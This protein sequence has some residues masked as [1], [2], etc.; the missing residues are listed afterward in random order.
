M[1][2]A[3]LV[4]EIFHEPTAPFCE[5]WVLGRIESILIQ[6]KIPFFYD[7]ARNLIAGVKSKSALKKVRVGFIAHADHPGFHIEKKVGKNKY[8][9]LWYGGA[10]FKKMKGA[11]IAIYHPFLPKEKHRGIISKFKYKTYL[12]EGIPFE[13]KTEKELPLVKGCFGAFDFPALEKKGDLIYTRVADDLTGVVIILG[14]LIDLK[15]KLSKNKIA[16]VF[17]RAEEVGWVGCWAI[18]QAKLF[19]KDISLVSLEAS[20][21]LPLAEIGKGPVLRIGD[22]ATIFDSDLSIALW[23][24]A[25]NSKVPFQR[26]VMDGGSCEASAANLFGYKTTGISIPLGNY[27]NEGPSGP[28]PEFVSLKDVDRARK[29]AKLF[30]QI[31]FHPLKANREVRFKSAQKNFKTLLPLLNQRIGF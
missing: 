3:S 16:G 2:T 7:D 26:R 15:K 4:H 14:L 22:R 11:E 12:R 25:R 21:T 28:A 18:L 24:V 30:A 17:T 23:D 6:H 31:F 13:I 8:K 5:G 10:P 9:A 19:S 27:H 29:I 20:K 1:H